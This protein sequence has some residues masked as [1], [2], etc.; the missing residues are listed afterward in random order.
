MAVLVLKASGFD[1]RNAV[2]AC[3]S[4]EV[5]CVQGTYEFTGAT[6]K[7]S[8][9]VQLFKFPA[10]H[11]PVDFILA[12][13]ALGD[14]MTF[15]VGFLDGTSAADANEFLSVINCSAATWQRMSAIGTL[16]VAATAAERIVGA[17]VNSVGSAVPEGTMHFQL[18]YRH[19]RYGT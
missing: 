2:D 3:Q 12:T 10:D 17:K 19:A 18:W 13:D 4:G 14:G 7:A 8:D 15:N 5:K 1:N 6:L 11:V 16:E 9:D